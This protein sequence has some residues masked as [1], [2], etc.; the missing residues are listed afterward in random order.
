MAGGTLASSASVPMFALAYTK[1]MLGKHMACGVYVG[2]DR[3]LSFCSLGLGIGIGIGIG[4]GRSAGCS[5]DLAS[6][7]PSICSSVFVGKIEWLGFLF[8][9]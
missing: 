9:K 1:Q 6:F 4:V 5:F 8:I 7:H 2:I 3:Q